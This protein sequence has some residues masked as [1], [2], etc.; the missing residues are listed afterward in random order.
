MY[1]LGMYVDVNVENIAC[2]CICTH[3]LVHIYMI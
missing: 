1:I 3:K 2:T